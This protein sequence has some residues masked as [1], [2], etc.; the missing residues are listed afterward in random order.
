MPV[1]LESFFPLLMPYLIQEMLLYL[2]NFET[3]MSVITSVPSV[4]HVEY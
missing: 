3:G 1:Q 4:A 2:L